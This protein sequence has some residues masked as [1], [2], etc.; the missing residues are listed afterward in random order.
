MRICDITNTFRSNRNSGPYGFHV[1][2]WPPYVAARP[3]SGTSRLAKTT[4]LSLRTSLATTGDETT[5]ASLVPRR[6]LNN[7]P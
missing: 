1:I 4:S 7:G 6:S 5:M 3:A 2:S